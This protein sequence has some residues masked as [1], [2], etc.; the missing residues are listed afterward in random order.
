M[1]LLTKSHF[2]S[3]RN[4]LLFVII[5]VKMNYYFINLITLIITIAK[6]LLITAGILLSF[7]SYFLS[8]S[9]K[10]E[11]FSYTYYKVKTIIIIVYR[12]IGVTDLF[13]RNH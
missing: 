8:H 2:I 4:Y 3:V 1:I 7:T 10:Y 13:L 11:S 5:I 9:I 12:H 6:F